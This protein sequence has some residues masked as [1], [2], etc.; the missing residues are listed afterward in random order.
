MNDNRRNGWP[1]GATSIAMTAAFWLVYWL[2]PNQ[3]VDAFLQSLPVIAP[4]LWILLWFF[5][6]LGLGVF[7][8]VRRSRAW[9]VAPSFAVATAAFFFVHIL[10]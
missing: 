2:L 5:I 10:A 1:F 8:A 3:K 4:L 7:A 6:A 9:L